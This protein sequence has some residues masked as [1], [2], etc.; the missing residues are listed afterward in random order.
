M[1]ATVTEKGGIDMGYDVAPVQWEDPPA[2]LV[3]ARSWVISALVEHWEDSNA[4]D[5]GTAT[6]NA[7]WMARHRDDGLADEWRRLRAAIKDGRPIVVYG[8]A[9]SNPTKAA[10]VE[11]FVE[12]LAKA[13]ANVVHIPTVTTALMA[14]IVGNRGLTAAQAE[15]MLVPPTLLHDPL[16]MNG[17]KETVAVVQR[18]ISEHRKIA[19]YGDFDSDGVTATAILVKALRAAGADVIPYIPNVENEGYGLHAE[20]F[21]ELGD[22]GVG[23]VISVDSGVSSSDVVATRPKGMLVAVT[24]HHLPLRPPGG[25]AEVLAGSD[26]LIDPVRDGDNYPFKELAGAG[27]AWKLVGALEQAGTVPPGTADS[28]I[29]LAALGTV[30]DVMELTDENRTIVTRGLA[31]LR[32]NPSPGLAALIEVAK[33]NVPRPLRDEDLQFSLIPRINAAGRMEDGMVALNLLLA[34]TPKE[35]SALAVKLNTLNEKRKLLTAQ[36]MVEAQ[37]QIAAL[38]ENSAALVLDSRDWPKGIVG[39]LAGKL[40]GMYNRTVIT[41]SNTGAEAKGSARSMGGVKI[42]D[43][44]REVSD[45]LVRYGGHDGAAGFSVD[46]ARIDEF[47]TRVEAAVAKQLTAKSRARV[48]QPDAIVDGREINRRTVDLV[49]KLEPFGNGNPEPVLEVRNAR[50]VH[51]DPLGQSGNHWKITLQDS[52]YHTFKAVLW[53]DPGAHD[54]L[55]TWDDK[56]QAWTGGQRVDVAGTIARN[57]WTADDGVYRENVQFTVDAIRPTQPLAQHRVHGRAVA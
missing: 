9:A 38:P 36:A 5:R 1:T 14:Q 16:E 26:S 23:A 29:S 53:S 44:L 56:T 41:I 24:D 40:A 55:M 18:A 33:L 46:P 39:A 35:A 30:G 32:N 19:V 43:A 47:R 48:L 7:R 10:Q 22:M 57:G 37:R 50:I 15:A 34:D 2:E 27:V 52:N 31:A 17:M 13:K 45:T 6:P 51:V 11:R 20:A 54:R 4:L 8:D 12:V 28:L 21:K 3:S 49:S 25:G 42:V